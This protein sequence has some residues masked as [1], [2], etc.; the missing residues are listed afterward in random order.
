MFVF[1]HN[2]ST[3]FI[4]YAEHVPLGW[5]VLVGSF[6]EEFISPIPAM[7]I[8][9]IAGSIALVRQE[10]WWYLGF[11]ALLASFGKTC[12]AYIYY[13]L[14][15]KGEDILVG[16]VGQWFGVTHADIEKVGQRFARQHWKDGG[17]LFLTRAFPF[18]PTT[19]F[20]M[21]A[22]IFKM[23][24][25]VYLFVTLGGYYIKDMG[26]LLVGYFGLAKLSTLW[27][28]IEHVKIIFDIG[29]FIFIGISLYLLYRHRRHG[30]SLWRS[31]CNFLRKFQS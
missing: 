7:F 13:R 30:W 8:T 20:S 21:A 19:P 12:G 16:R 10:E 5:F 18:M 2:L 27:R 15:D 29:S 14:G 22:G 17:A 24:I 4:W 3:W 6:L 31:C 23:D 26:Y 9:G 25:R 1:E 28:D 11:L